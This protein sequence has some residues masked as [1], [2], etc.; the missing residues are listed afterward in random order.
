MDSIILS[1]AKKDIPLYFK[2][3]ENFWNSTNTFFN[4]KDLTNCYASTLIFKNW[5]ISLNY[6]KITNLNNVLN[7]L[8]EDINTS[9]FHAYLG[10]YRS[11]HMHLRV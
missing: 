9:F 7:E 4:D 11:A 2:D 1:N 6:I 5:K 3:F 10:Y 8:H